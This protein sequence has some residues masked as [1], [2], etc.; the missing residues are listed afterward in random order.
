M[1]HV[2]HAYC[3]LYCGACP[4]MVNT[5]ARTGTEQCG[6]CKSEQTT[7]YCAVC[8]IKRCAQSR[9]HGFCNE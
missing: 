6:G 2:L 9:G 7:G 4:V 3:G 8:G 1:E 5:Q